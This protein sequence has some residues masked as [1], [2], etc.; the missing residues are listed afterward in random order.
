MPEA[1]WSANVKLEP[2]SL[3][4]T[5]TW[6]VDAVFAV[7]VLLEPSRLFDGSERML[8]PNASDGSIRLVTCLFSCTVDTSTPKA[9]P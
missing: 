2:T 6:P 3:V 7:P 5:V 8:T 1:T 9:T 4:S